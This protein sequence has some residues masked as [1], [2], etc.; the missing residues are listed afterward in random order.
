ML[1]KRNLGAR[2]II[3]AG[4]G[5]AIWLQSLPV[6]GQ[7]NSTANP[8]AVGDASA[9]STAKPFPDL[10]IPGDADQ[11][12]LLKLLAVAKQAQPSSAEQYRQMQLAIRDASDRLVKLIADPVDPV[13]L[14]AELDVLASSAALMV[15][16]SEEAREEVA[17]RV[18][19]LFEKKKE[20]TLTD[21]QSGMMIAFY[22]ELQPRKSPARDVYAMLE[23]RLEGDSREEMQALRLNLQANVRRLELLGNKLPLD[24]KDIDGHRIKTEDFAGKFLLVE[25]FASWCQPC[26]AEVPRLKKHYAKYRDKGLEIISIGLDQDR[27]ALDKYVADQILTWPVIFDG[28]NPLEQKWQMKFGISS[29]PSI[30]LLNKE[31]VVVSLE[32]RGPELDRLMER[33]FEMP[34][35]ADAPKPADPSAPAK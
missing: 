3:V 32:A 2:G 34:T 26:V 16:E 27:A 12:A 19:A 14:Q 25:F 10:T 11:V 28:D 17:S 30:L 31:G 33:I 9:V 6:L 7:T 21:I 24:A 1:F 18:M 35:P 22:L 20:L 29:L 5:C 4:F 23:Q 15:N 13:R 8:P